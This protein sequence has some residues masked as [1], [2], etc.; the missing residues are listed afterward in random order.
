MFTLILIALSGIAIQLDTQN[1]SPNSTVLN[2]LDFRSLLVGI[3]SRAT[4][5]DWGE[6]SQVGPL[7]IPSPAIPQ[8]ASNAVFLTGV[9]GFLGDCE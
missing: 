3:S 7:A 4:G 5:L 9:T 2:D 8:V 6:E 1:L